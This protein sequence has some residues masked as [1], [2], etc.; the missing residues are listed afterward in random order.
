MLIFEARSHLPE[1]S[2]HRHPTIPHHRRPPLHP[3][4][5]GTL[6]TTAGIVL[7]QDDSHL[8]HDDTHTVVRAVYRTDTCRPP[9]TPE[10]SPPGGA[11]NQARTNY[12]CPSLVVLTARNPRPILEMLTARE[13][14]DFS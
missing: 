10:A 11:K 8:D 14:G 12:S 3:S 1:A 4:E 9:H 6:A 7:V 5:A 13:N 2:Q